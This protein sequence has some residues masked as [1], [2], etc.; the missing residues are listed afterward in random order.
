MKKEE[1]RLLEEKENMT[2]KLDDYEKNLEMNSLNNN[3]DKKEK[4]KRLRKKKNEILRS[5]V[6]HIKNC[7][8]SYGLFKKI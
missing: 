5:F 2:R 3:E 7:E 8:K 4:K 6:C 1:N